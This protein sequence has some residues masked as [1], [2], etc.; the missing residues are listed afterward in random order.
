MHDI[1]DI[2]KDY[3]KRTNDSMKM[4]LQALIYIDIRRNCSF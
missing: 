3:E 2:Y 1:C 4:E